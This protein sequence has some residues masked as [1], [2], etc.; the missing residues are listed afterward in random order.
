MPAF[1]D[2]RDATMAHFKAFEHGSGGTFL[3]SA[4]RYLFADICNILR[5]NF[6]E[7]KERIP[8]P[9]KQDQKIETYTVDCKWTEGAGDGVSGLGR[10]SLGYDEEYG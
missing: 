2:V 5:D 1:V 7:H 3:P 9:T 10:V 4:G 6:P 8:E